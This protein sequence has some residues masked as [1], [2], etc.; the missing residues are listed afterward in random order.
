MKD[1][2]LSINLIVGGNW[3]Q[4][5]FLW[6]EN[7]EEKNGQKKNPVV[8]WSAQ[9]PEQSLKKK[10]GV[11]PQNGIRTTA[12]SPRKSKTFELGKEKFA[13]KSRLILLAKEPEIRQYLW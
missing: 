3:T 8:F 13:R 6:K 10:N 5:W 9:N 12:H 1:E 2:E 7:E 11:L 4:N